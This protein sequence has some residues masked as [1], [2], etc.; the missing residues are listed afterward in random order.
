MDPSGL[1]IHLHDSH[2]DAASKSSFRDGLAAHLMRSVAGT[3]PPFVS[4]FGVCLSCR[5]ALSEVTPCL[6]NL[7][8]LTEQ[9]GDIR[10]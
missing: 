3:Q 8:P 5:V 10:A 6:G 7:H 4:Y 1:C 2:E 9:E